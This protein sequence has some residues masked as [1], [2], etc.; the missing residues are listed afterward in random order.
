MSEAKVYL[1]NLSYDARERWVANNSIMIIMII[2]IPRDLEKFL[3]GYGRIRTIQLKVTT[4][5]PLFLFLFNSSIISASLAFILL[6]FPPL[7]GK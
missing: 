3:K 7:G 2:M 5:L 1:G 6:Y 4:F